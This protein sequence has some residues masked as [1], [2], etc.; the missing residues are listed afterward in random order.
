MSQSIVGTSASTR[1]AAPSNL[2]QRVL[3]EDS[4]EVSPISEIEDSESS[5]QSNQFV[6][7]HNASPAPAYPNAA[8]AAKETVKSTDKASILGRL[9]DLDQSIKDWRKKERAAKKSGNETAKARCRKT[10]KHLRAERAS[11]AAKVNDQSGSKDRSGNSD[12]EVVEASSSRSSIDSATA[13]NEGRKKLASLQRALK[14]AI[15]RDDEDVAESLEKEIKA[16]K[17]QLRISVSESNSSGSTIPANS[18]PALA[19]QPPGEKSAMERVKDLYRDVC[20]EREQARGSLANLKRNDQITDQIKDL[21]SRI[22]E[23]DSEAAALET[24][25][26]RDAHAKEDEGAT[27]TGLLEADKNENS[28][29][30]HA[31]TTDTREVTGNPLSKR[32]DPKRNSALYPKDEIRDLLNTMAR[33]KVDDIK[34][35]TDAYVDEIDRLTE[36]REELQQKIGKERNRKSQKNLVKELAALDKQ[37]FSMVHKANRQV[38]RTGKIEER[39]QPQEQALSAKEKQERY[40]TLVEACK[41]KETRALEKT[42]RDALKAYIDQTAEDKAGTTVRIMAGGGVANFFTF[43]VGNG[44]TRGL[45]EVFSKST[46]PFL[47]YALGSVV[48]GGLHAVLTTPILKQIMRESWTSPALAEYNNWWKLVGASWADYRRGEEKI[49]KYPSKDP[50]KR[51][52][53]TIDERLAEE[54]SFR[55]LFAARYIV[56][57]L[58][59]FSFMGNYLLKATGAAFIP[60][61]GLDR[62]SSVGIESAMQIPDGWVSGAETSLLIHNFRSEIPGAKLLPSPPMAVCA[63]EAAYLDSLVEDLMKARKRLRDNVKRDPADPTDRELLKAIHKT[64]KAADIARRKSGILG[65]LWHEVR[66]QFSSKDAIADTIAEAVAR[67]VVLLESAGASYALEAW[68]KSPDPMT[69]FLGHAIPAILLIQPFGGWTSRGLV[70]GL[71]RA[72]IQC[73]INE[74]AKDVT[75]GN[76]ESAI[77]TVQ[78][79]DTVKTESHDGTGEGHEV[80]DVGAEESSEIVSAPADGEVSDSDDEWAGNERK[81]Y[82]AY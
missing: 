24:Y 6:R 13:D 63:A 14:R 30:G 7:H 8:I 26:S 58:P 61:M 39:V 71:A 43:S 82:V 34:F 31:T 25:I 60:H 68:R 49:A 54:K 12:D 42:Y 44:A 5:E 17:R 62:G 4:S 3:G 27:G 29:A 67:I 52:L 40:E 72:I 69:A 64:K 28:D 20:D 65:T 76:K 33:E 50:S 78:V 41:S 55:N 47:S 22:E 10:L 18:T 73:F 15:G 48:A 23:L 66:S 45:A 57:E 11:L 80:I 38:K 81:D 9:N 79:P 2:T 70:S 37:I 21:E 77:K 36:L 75:S 19:T 16:L 53:L 74:R 46:M 32:K 56:E 59:Y 35:Q 51:G 1:P